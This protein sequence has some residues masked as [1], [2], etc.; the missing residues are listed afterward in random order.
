[1]IIILT[2]LK[3]IIFNKYHVS[4]IQQNKNVLFL[5]KF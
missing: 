2:F 5:Q 3:I 4:K 1:M